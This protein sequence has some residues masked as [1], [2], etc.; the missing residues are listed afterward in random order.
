MKRRKGGGEAET[1]GRNGVYR[2]LFANMYVCALCAADLRKWTSFWGAAARWCRLTARCMHTAVAAGVE[3]AE[4]LAER[5]VARKGMEASSLLLVCCSM[6]GTA[7]GRCRCCCSCSSWWAAAIRPMTVLRVVAC[8]LHILA[9]HTLHVQ[10]LGPNVL[11]ISHEYE[12]KKKFVQLATF[13]SDKN[14]KRFKYL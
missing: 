6:M 8:T 12:W 9:S 2:I 10:K 11:Q 7:T 13:Q 1:A 14:L 4:Q 3:H 5:G